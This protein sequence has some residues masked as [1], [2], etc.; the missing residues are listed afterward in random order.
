MPDMGIMRAPV[1]PVTRT[2]SPVRQPS[3]GLKMGRTAFLPILALFGSLLGGCRWISI[4]PPEPEAA[5]EQFGPLVGTWVS[6]EGKPGERTS[7]TEEVWTRPA[8]D[9]LMGVSR[10]H[11]THQN[12]A[13]FEFLRIVAQGDSIVYLA[14]PQGRHPPIEFT[15]RPGKIAGVWSFWNL[16]HDFPQVIS[17]TLDGGKRLEVRISNVEDAETAESADR[18]Q[19]PTESEPAARSSRSWRFERVR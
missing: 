5:L 10:T 2:R 19:S 17:Y 7:W 9:S 6:V 11:R 3:A 4:A 12:E 13:E 18:D 8:S 16:D 14:S 1:R 15:L